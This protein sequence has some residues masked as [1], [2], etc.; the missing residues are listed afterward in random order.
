M[1][2]QYAAADWKQMQE[3]YEYHDELPEHLQL[4]K[5]EIQAFKKL[6]KKA[7]NQVCS[8]S[9]V[10]DWFQARA[11]EIYDSGAKE[12]SIPTPTGSVQ[13]MFYPV[14]EVKQ[15]KSFY[16]GSLKYKE[17][18]ETKLTEYYPTDKPDIKK[19]LSS[20]TANAIHSLDG[21]CLAIGLH[22]F[23]ESFSTVHDAIY[24]Y[25]GSTMDDILVKLKQSFK[26]TVEFDIWGEFLR[27]N[28]LPEDNPESY[29][30]IVGNLDLNK[31]LESD[32]IFA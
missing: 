9:F 32:Y 1:V 3:F 7:M 20:I 13:K 4:D 15:V 30:P 16:S 2:A 14:Y 21:S 25:A 10:V 19:W 31:V 18:K 23:P 8:F 6:W 28:N 26:E 11:Q 22:D 5:A 27:A 12:I 29:P 24:C 17:E